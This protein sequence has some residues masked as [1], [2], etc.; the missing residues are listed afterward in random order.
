MPRDV[1]HSI[2]LG[3]AP[4]RQ[5]WAQQESVRDLIL[6]AHERDPGSSA[7]LERLFLVEHDPVITLGRSADERNVLTADGVELVRTTRGGDVTVHGPGQLVVYPVIRLVKGVVHTLET[8][9]GAIADELAARGVAA[10]FQ[11]A[12][13]GVWV[14]GRKIAACGIHVKRRVMI[15]GFAINVTRA[16]LALFERIVPCGLPGATTT[17]IEDHAA[18]PALHELANAI[19]ARVSHALGRVP[20]ALDRNQEKRDPFVDRILRSSNVPLGWK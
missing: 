13:A 6:A 10:A 4:Y 12:P 19:A 11:R 1:L 3:R 5:V 9:G 7:A 17:T 15:H 16:C 8:V 2:W 20:V 14:G 18:P